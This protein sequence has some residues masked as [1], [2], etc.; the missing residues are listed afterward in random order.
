MLELSKAEL[1]AQIEALSQQLEVV[2]EE[3]ADLDIMMETI[4]EHSTSLENEIHKKNK[5]M[6]GYIQQVE[7]LTDAATAVETNSFDPETLSEVAARPDELGNLARIF[8]QM[9]QTVKIRERELATAKEQLEAVLN[10]VP[11]SISWINANGVYVGVNHHLAQ[12]WN[13]PPEAFV[14]KQLGF[15]K[16][17]YQ[18]AKF[19]REFLAS[20]RESASHIVE[21]ESGEAV[22]YYLIATQKYQQGQSTVSVGIDITERKQAEEAL[23]IAEENYRSI[24]ENALEGIFQSQP[25]GTY[26]S[27]NP[28]MARIY[29]YDSPE[30]LMQSVTANSTQ[31]YVDPAQR[32][33]FRRRIEEDGEVKGWEYQVYRQDGCAIWIE[34]NTRAVRDRNGNLLYYE[35]IVKEITQ[36]KQEE[37]DL[38]RQLQELRVEIDQ[39]K[40]VREVAEITQAGYFKELQAEVG[41][42]ELDE[43]WEI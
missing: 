19:I 12:Q 30:A 11:G 43:F 27:V 26:I 21:V 1:L 10:A 20:S 22:R 16:E 38:K 24:F 37:E 32:E 4:N 39:Q 7:K 23:R 33:A 35:G 14:G 41:D 17:G 36:R 31:V 6:R 3:K 34:E 29:G 5:Q 8:T 18:F 42:I 13:L 25:D 40:R 28:A 2:S 9:V 15:L